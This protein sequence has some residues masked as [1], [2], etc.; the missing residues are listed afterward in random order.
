MANYDDMRK[1]VV[2]NNVSNKWVVP[3]VNE[4]MTLE[5]MLTNR[6]TLYIF[7][8]FWIEKLAEQKP[9]LFSGNARAITNISAIMEHQENLINAYNETV[10]TLHPG[11][12]AYYPDKP[13]EC[14]Y[15]QEGESACKIAINEQTKHTIALLENLPP[16]SYIDPTTGEV[17]N[18]G[19]TGQN[20][21]DYAL[22]IL[23]ALGGVIV[24]KTF[25]KRKQRAA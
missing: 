24:Y 12:S 11:M 1:D 23:L 13:M 15:G 20:K 17:V 25:F 10:E 21:P 8:E 7:Q 9:G 19:D 2:S 18:A 22:Y 4:T 5:T 14:T 16:G 3:P 6:D